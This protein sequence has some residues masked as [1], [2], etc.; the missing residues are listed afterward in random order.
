MCVWRRSSVGV[1][2]QSDCCRRKFKQRNC[3]GKYA[4]KATAELFGTRSQTKIDSTTRVVFSGTVW[5]LK[6]LWWVVEFLL[7]SRGACACEGRLDAEV[8]LVLADKVTSCD[9]GRVRCRTRC[10]VRC[11]GWRGGV[12]AAGGCRRKYLSIRRCSE[13]KLGHGVRPSRC[14]T[15]WAVV[16]ARGGIASSTRTVHHC[17]RRLPGV[18]TRPVRPGAAEPC[19][20][21]P[22]DQ[23]AGKMR[24]RRGRDVTR[25]LPP[26]ANCPR[27]AVRFFLPVGGFLPGAREREKAEWGARPSEGVSSSSAVAVAVVAVAVRRRRR[28]LRRV[29]FLPPT[30]RDYRCHGILLTATNCR[31]IITQHKRS[32]CARWA[33]WKKR[34][35]ERERARAS[36]W[37]G[38]RSSVSPGTAAL[39]LRR[40]FLRPPLDGR[41]DPPP[42]KIAPYF[43]FRPPPATHFSPLRADPRRRIEERAVCRR[44]P[45][46]PSRVA[47]SRPGDGST[48]WQHVVI[49]I[50]TVSVA[51]TVTVVAVPKRCCWHLPPTNRR[52]DDVRARME[53]QTVV[54]R[55]RPCSTAPADGVDR[56]VNGHYSAPVSLPRYRDGS[57]T[58]FMSQRSHSLRIHYS[59]RNHGQ[60]KTQP[61]DYELNTPRN[62]VH[63]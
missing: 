63:H 59:T 50:V 27:S 56:G 39:F 55:R 32:S 44:R 19:P 6:R 34:A 47:Q 53:R 29:L 30:E 7:V 14:W 9:L 54:D 52:A 26:G 58:N 42:L 36:V 11:G 2:G 24:R 37:R 51:V 38:W 35:G 4:L 40:A 5:F 10:R 45:L 57:A 8:A 3:R 23:S 25:P 21:D 46:P 20:R 31:P 61:F 22:R 43:F 13:A 49:V 16:V 62:R 18:M 1:N 17:T 28:R 33:P 15:H 48:S 41:I 60:H 12:R